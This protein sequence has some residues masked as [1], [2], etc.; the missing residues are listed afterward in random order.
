MMFRSWIWNVED[1]SACRCLTCARWRGQ[2]SPSTL[3]LTYSLRTA[4]MAKRLVPLLFPAVDQPLSKLSSQVLLD[5]PRL[6]GAQPP[7]RLGNAQHPPRPNY[8]K[9]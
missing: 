9:P 8:P 4:R 6:A 7:S 5:C 2:P 3:Q 1:S